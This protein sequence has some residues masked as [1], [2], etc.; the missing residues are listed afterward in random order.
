MIIKVEQLRAEHVAKCLRQ[1]IADEASI[2]SIWLSKSI[3]FKKLCRVDVATV[4]TSNGWRL[5]LVLEEEGVSYVK[6]AYGPDGS[7]FLSRSHP[8]AVYD[9]LEGPEKAVFDA[10]LQH[11]I[12]ATLP[13]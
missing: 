2:T 1:V 4:Q 6:A 8:I 9:Q 12:T 13:R 3:N 11:A 7:N 10:A 5:E